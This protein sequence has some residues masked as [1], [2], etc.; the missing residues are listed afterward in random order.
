MKLF[1]EDGTYE[2]VEGGRPGCGKTQKVREQVRNAAPRH[3]WLVN[4][5]WEPSEIRVL[6]LARA[7]PLDVKYIREDLSSGRNSSVKIICL[8]GS[9]RF[10]DTWINEYQRLSD[11]GNIVLTVARMPPRPNLQHE[12]PELKIKLDNL[13]LRKID[14][15][16]EIFVLNVGGYVGDSTKREIE[17]AKSKN[18][19]V[20]FLV[21]IGVDC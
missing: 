19:V 10:V 4:G 17:Y 16:D 6:Q 13:H 1:K 18:K 12:D 15:A 9:T 14:L 11:D 2:L 7:T 3:I 21:G 20:K 5:K 8:C